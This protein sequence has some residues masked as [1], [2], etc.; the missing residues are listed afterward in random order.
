MFTGNFRLVIGIRVWFLDWFGWNR[1]GKP[2]GNGV[3]RAWGDQ[4]SKVSSLSEIGQARHTI[5]Y[6]RFK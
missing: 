3:R 6:F 4:F 2:L 5:G 1:K